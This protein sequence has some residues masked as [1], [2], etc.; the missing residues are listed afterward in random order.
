MKRVEPTSIGELLDG[1]F[2][3]P[4]IAAKIVEGSLPET[5]RRVVGPVVAAE[6]RQV[7]F[8]RG[9]LYV[10]V[11]SSVIR[12]ELMRQ[13]EALMAALNREA[14]MAIVKSVVVQ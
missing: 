4:N 14:G 2:K 8:V 7:R 12:A 11:T 5:W 3:S 9:T 10:H 1:L 6:T 13:R